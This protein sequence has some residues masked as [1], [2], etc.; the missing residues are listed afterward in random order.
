MNVKALAPGKFALPQVT[1][2]ESGFLA[3]SSSEAAAASAFAAVSVP[4]L[5]CSDSKL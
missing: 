2:F 5:A 4:L 1:A 3:D